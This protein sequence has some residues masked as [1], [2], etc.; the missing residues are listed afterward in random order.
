[1]CVGDPPLIVYGCRMG[2]EWVWEKAQALIEGHPKRDE[3]VEE[4]PRKRQRTGKGKGNKGYKGKGSNSK[5]Y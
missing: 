2:W 1:M 3:D 5:G 4:P